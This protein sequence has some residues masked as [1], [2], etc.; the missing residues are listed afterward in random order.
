MY[1][2]INTMNTNKLDCQICVSEKH[3]S[4]FITCERCSKQ[5]CM[6]CY[7][8]LRTIQCPYCRFSY[9]YSERQLPI[10]EQVFNQI[11]NPEE[12]LLMNGGPT[13][14]RIFEWLYRNR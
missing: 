6:S 1:Y 2:N 12:T 8:N 11:P 7:S 13:D 5:I 4:D 10:S 3:L 9:V 14:I